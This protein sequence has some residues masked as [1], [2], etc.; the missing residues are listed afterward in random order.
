MNSPAKNV[1]GMAIASMVLGIV[2][3]VFSFFCYPIGFI[4]AL[5]GLPLGA[6]AKAQISK[7]TA[8]REGN[9]QAVTGIVLGIITLAIAV[10]AM[11]AFG[12]AISE[13]E[14]SL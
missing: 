6:V 12:A 5:V 1:K 11:I 4:C 3:I 13:F 14:S 2:G 7:G 8:S 10:L 9:G